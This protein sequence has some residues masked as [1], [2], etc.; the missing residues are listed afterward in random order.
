MYTAH[1]DHLGIRPEM[2]GDNIYNGA[3]D[4]ATRLWDSART[5]TCFS[6]RPRSSHG[7]PFCLRL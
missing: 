3:D 6:A 4:N 5:G 1:Y 2:P 7:A